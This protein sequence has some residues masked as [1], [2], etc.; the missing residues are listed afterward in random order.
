MNTESSDAGE[1]Q[2]DSIGDYSLLDARHLMAA[3]AQARIE[4]Q[5]DFD[6]G[7]QS[8]GRSQ[9]GRGGWYAEVALKVDLAR[10]GEVCK[11]QAELFGDCTTT[12]HSEEIGS[13]D[14]EPTECLS[15]GTMIPAG[16]T[17]CPKCGWTY[18]T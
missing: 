17:H 1:K 10:M 13:S 3:F 6:D 12:P 15:C 14:V 2:F 11:I 18:E 9:Y 16:V 8:H 7:V 4:F 5:A